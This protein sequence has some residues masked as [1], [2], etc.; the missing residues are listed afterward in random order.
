M[1]SLNLPQILRLLPGSCCR[2]AGPRISTDHA[3]SDAICFVFSVHFTKF[4]RTVLDL[5]CLHTSFP[6]LLTSY[7]SMVHLSQLMNQY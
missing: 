7:I 1:G 2:A 6:L 5:E 4:F 3:S